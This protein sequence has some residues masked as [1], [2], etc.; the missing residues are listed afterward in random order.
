MDYQVLTVALRGNY[1][2]DNHSLTFGYELEALD[3]FN[4]FIQHTETEIRFN[5]LAD[6][7]NMIADDIYYNNSPSHNPD[8]AAA[9][10]GYNVNTVYIQDEFMVGDRLTLVAG[11]R[12]DWYTTSDEPALNTEFQSEYGFGNNQTLDGEGLTQP[13][14]GFTFDMTDSTVVHGGIG[15]YSGGNPNVWLSNNYSADNTRQ[16]G[17]YAR[18]YD[19]TGETYSGCEAGVPTGPGW[20]IPDVVYDQVSTGSGS[21]FE[22]NYLDPNFKIPSELKLSL[23]VTHEM[24]SDWVVGVDFLYSE[25]KDAAMIRHGDLE[26]I[27]TDPDGYPEYDSV[28]MASFVLT[29]SN[30]KP[31]STAISL[32]VEKQWDNFYFRAGYAHTSAKDVQPMTSSVAFSN[33]QNRAF[34]DPEEDV[35]STSNYEIKHRASFAARWN[36]ELGSSMNLSVSLYGHYNSG[37]PYSFT[38]NGTIDPY[39]FTPYLDFRDNVLEPGDRRNEHTGSS[40]KKLDMRVALDFPGFQPDHQ[41][42]AFLVIDN[43]T[44]LLNDDWGVLYQHNFPRTVVRG[45]SESRIGDASRYEIRMGLK[46]DF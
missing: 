34:F 7:E 45:T 37:R 6:F 33:Y 21:N 9:D 40:W 23:G 12:H 30:R 1:D 8:D 18:D 29:N 25:L 41:A 14:L 27:G 15:V 11:V 10:W 35:V 26:Q 16:F 3:I 4:L 24:A 38:Y 28:R 43:L 13:R 31:K 32:G 19:L 36:R 44:N 22:I 2:M 42:S 39:G 17:A 20:C 5:G 46:Y